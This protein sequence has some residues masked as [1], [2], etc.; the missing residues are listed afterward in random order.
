MA[1]TIYRNR[2]NRKFCKEHGIR[3]SGLRLGRPKVDEIEADKAQ[4]RRD[5]CDRNIVE[6]RNGIAKR[7]YGLNRI[8]AYLD[9][10]AK[11][12]AAFIMLAMNAGLCLRTLLRLFFKRRF[13]WVFGL[14]PSEL[15]NQG[16][17]S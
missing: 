9:G 11:S 3:L 13:H 4:A 15:Q 5:S 10:T 2:E 6:S 8:L 1:D 7:R 12:E 16:L 17:F 14:F